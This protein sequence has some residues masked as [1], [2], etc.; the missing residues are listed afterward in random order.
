[1][2]HAQAVRRRGWVVIFLGLLL[3]GVMGII[4]YN[5]AP[6]MLS[7]SASAGARFTGTPQQA[8]LI[9]ALFGLVIAVGLACVGGGLWQIA[10]GR[11]NIWIFVLTLGLTFLL[12][13]AGWRVVQMPD[14]GGVYMKVGAVS[15]I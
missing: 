14:R 15:S 13:A 9:L 2:R 6:T 8:V 7:G 10:T 5:V 4:T 3:A 12:I 1:M 11:R